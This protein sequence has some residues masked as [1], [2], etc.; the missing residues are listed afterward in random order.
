VLLVFRSY[1][2]RCGASNPLET[3]DF[4][5]N[6]LGFLTF[7]PFLVPINLGTIGSSVGSSCSLEDK[8]GNILTGRADSTAVREVFDNI[9]SIFSHR[10]KVECVAS[11]VQSEDHIKLL[12]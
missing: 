5:E 6:L 3:V 7:D 2:L 12:D 1:S 11:R 8:L 9:L 4:L 10:A